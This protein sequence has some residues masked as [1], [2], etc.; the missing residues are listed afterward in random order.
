MFVKPA[1]INVLALAHLG[2][3]SAC[4]V[5]EETRETGSSTRT[6]EKAHLHA[7]VHR[8]V[9]FRPSSYQKIRRRTQGREEIIAARE[10]GCTS[11]GIAYEARCP[12]ADFTRHIERE[13]IGVACHTLEPPF[14]NRI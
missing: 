1:P 10:I 6:A 11:F 12:A 5:V 13:L 9:L 3:L 8:P 2:V 7:K 14:R 4:R